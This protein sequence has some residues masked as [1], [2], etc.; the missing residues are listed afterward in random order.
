MNKVYS[1]IIGLSAGVALGV[2]LIALFS[3]VSG[4]EVIRRLKAS[5]DETLEEARLAAES[6]RKELEA[7]LAKMQKSA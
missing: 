4:D 1:W 3:P 6:K 2:L 5:F 7:E